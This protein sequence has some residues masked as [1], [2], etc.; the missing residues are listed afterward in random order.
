MALSPE[1]ETLINNYKFLFRN[2]SW[3]RFSPLKR[4]LR[5]ELMYPVAENI[6]SDGVDMAGIARYSLAI[7]AKVGKRLMFLF[8]H[9]KGSSFLSMYSALQYKDNSFSSLS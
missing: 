6:L 5:W 9:G 4:D 2:T 7:L 3:L 1:L 8:H